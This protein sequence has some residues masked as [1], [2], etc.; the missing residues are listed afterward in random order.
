[1][2]RHDIVTVLACDESWE[3]ECRIEAVRLDG[4]DISI[5]KNIPRTAVKL[6]ETP[7]GTDHHTQWRPGEGWC[8]IRRS[9]GFPIIRGHGLE[10]AAIAQFHRE[11]P[12]PVV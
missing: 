10:G 12:R 2:R 3:L 5:S 6:A 1:L 8:V 7:L 4:C 9:D 11:Q